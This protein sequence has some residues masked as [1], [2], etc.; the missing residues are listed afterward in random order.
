MIV[1]SSLQLGGAEAM[2][3]ELANALAS[4]GVDTGFAG[5]D[6]PLRQNL[7][8][9]VAFLPTGV[10]NDAPVRG[11]GE[12]VR[13]MNE[14]R[15]EVIH[16]HGGVSSFVAAAA[17]WRSRLSPARVVTHHSR[18]FWRSPRLSGWLLGRTSD[19]FIAISSSKRD[20]LEAIG[21]APKRISH[22]PNFVDTVAVRERAQSVDRAAVLGELGIDPDA[23][24][25]CVAGRAVP[26]KRFDRFARIVALTNERLDRAV[27]GI[28]LGDGP[29]LDD[30]RRAALAAGAEGNVHFPGYQS[31]VIRY[32]AASD[33]VLFPTDHPEVLPMLL[34]E[35]LA[36]GVPVVCSDIP[37]NRDIIDEG[38]TGV[39]V[40]GDDNEY[41][42]ALAT[43]LSDPGMGERMSQVGRERARERFDKKNVVAATIQ[44]YESLLRTR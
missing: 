42:V 2:S 23:L 24:L 16:S 28:A 37:G 27:H 21:I 44:V 36:V 8:D 14:W 11:V 22:I 31:D 26:A 9:G 13:H 34:I 6:G 10:L 43:I 5:G 30:A 17:A 25:V 41:A 32:L 33:A 18:R 39:F 40:D 1:N 15:P 19:H 29:A 20:S 3:V 7:F 35:S 4:H 12:L 38:E